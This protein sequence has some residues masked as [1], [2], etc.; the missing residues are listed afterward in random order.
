MRVRFYFPFVLLGV[1]FL[2][3]SC[4]YDKEDVLYGT[5]CD[6]SN[7]RFNVEIKNILN[8][9]CAGCHSGN[10]TGGMG[11]KLET[12][13]EVKDAAEN[14]MFLESV[15]RDNNPMPKNASRLSACKINQIRAWINQGMKEN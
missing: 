12:Y 11:I 1:V 13:Q 10:A 7:V 4:Y 8:A 14:E 15:I 5:A 9:H 3:S 6:T 2:F